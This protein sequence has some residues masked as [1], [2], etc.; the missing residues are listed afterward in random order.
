MHRRNTLASLALT[1]AALG[2][3]LSGGG[4]SSDS[5]AGSPVPPS[6]ATAD[7]PIPPGEAPPAQPT[8]RADAVRFLEQTSFGPT[9]AAVDQVMQKG[10]AL[11]L[12][13]QFYKGMS[14]Y[15]QYFVVDQDSS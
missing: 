7:Q 12:V 3:C 13:E 10:A 1:L 14:G 6:N 2:G 4:G 5:P 15:P 9:P 11:V 8:S